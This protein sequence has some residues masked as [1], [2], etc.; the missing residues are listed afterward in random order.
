MD[1]L[2]IQTPMGNMSAKATNTVVY[3]LDFAEDNMCQ[4]KTNNSL[5]LQLETELIEY[6]NGKRREFE[7]GVKMG[8]R[9]S[10]ISWKRS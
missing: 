10:F 2:T 6:F 7:M 8:V 5:L 3:F 1:A 9:H 4:T